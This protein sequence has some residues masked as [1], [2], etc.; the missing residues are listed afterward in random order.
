MKI[1][2][3]THAGRKAYLELLSRYVLNDQNVS[4]WHLWDNCRDPSD[5]DYINELARLHSKI[6][7]V[8]ATDVCGTNRSVNK[9]YRNCNDP[10]VFYIKIDDDVVY[11]QEGTFAHMLE[12]AL[13]T[14]DRYI[15]WSPL[16]INNALCSYLIKHRSSLIEIAPQLT[17]QA[18]CPLGWRSPVF[19]IQLHQAFLNLNK[20]QALL[21]ENFDVSLSR[22]SINCIGFFGIDLVQ[23]GQMFCPLNVDDE[24]WITGV[25]PVLTQRSGRILGNYT[26]SHYSFFTQE[27]LLNQTDILDRYYSI[28]GISRKYAFP[29]ARRPG[30]LFRQRLFLFL[31]RSIENKL[32]GFDPKKE[33]KLMVNVVATNV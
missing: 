15:W 3:V 11:I 17:A 23:L 26:V 25:L 9:F 10:D 27:Y 24:E 4:E 20:K 8:H 13:K 12:E 28:A 22:F 14:R 21:H 1:I 2:V 33:K 32:T 7:I 19:A 18:S 6:K 5:R 30:Y 31:R 16:V 29:K